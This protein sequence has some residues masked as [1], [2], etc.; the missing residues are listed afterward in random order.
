[1]PRRDSQT[2]SGRWRDPSATRMWPVRAGQ[3]L[4]WAAI[5]IAVTGGLRAWLVDS[6][7]AIADAAAERAVA[8]ERQRE[9]DP[10]ATTARVE[11][12]AVRFVTLWAQGLPTDGLTTD[13]IPLGQPQPAPFL[14]EV[15]NTIRAGQR[16]PSGDLLWRVTVR[17]VTQPEDPERQGLSPAEVPVAQGPVPAGA[18]P[19]PVEEWFDLRAVSNADGVWVAGAP[20]PTRPEPPA[21]PAPFMPV[22]GAD[23]ERDPQLVEDLQGFLHRVADR[24]WTARPVDQRRR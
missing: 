4:A 11:R 7:A 17:T 12:L 22:G 24:N 5:L 1:M 23:P 14:I 15:R 16:L 3:T 6:D 19:E 2:R 18:A 21:P 9:A 8:A 10:A 20:T 13:P